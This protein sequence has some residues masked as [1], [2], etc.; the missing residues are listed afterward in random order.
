MPAADRRPAARVLFPI[1]LCT[2]LATARAQA[3]AIDK[4]SPEQAYLEAGGAYTTLLIRGSALDQI[5]GYEVRR[6]GAASTY[7]WAQS[8]PVEN[9]RTGVILLARADAPRD[10][11]Y[12]LHFLTAAGTGGALPLVLTVVEPGDPRALAEAGATARDAVNA[13]AGASS[14]VISAEQTPHITSTRP[15]PSRGPPQRHFHHPG[16]AGEKS[17]W[18]QRGACAARQPARALSR[19]AGCAGLPPHP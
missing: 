3:P 9:G 16:F 8:T 17:G 19:A 13:A 14:V 5:T 1:L 11:A 7:L 10:S 12:T 2:A 18:D 6:E 4:I 15:D